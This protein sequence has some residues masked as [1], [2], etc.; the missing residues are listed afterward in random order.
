MVAAEERNRA[1][2]AVKDEAERVSWPVIVSPDFLTN[3]PVD[4]I[5]A[6]SEDCMPPV[7]VIMAAVERATCCVK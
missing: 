6:S 5:T 1:V 2:V 4:T 7:E 3:P